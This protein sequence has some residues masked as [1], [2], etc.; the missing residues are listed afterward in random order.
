MVIFHSYVKLPEGTF[1]CFLGQMLVNIP[2][3]WSILGIVVMEHSRN[4]EE[5][6]EFKI[7]CFA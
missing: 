5:T 1:G 6:V 2:A 4:R 3:P 7:I